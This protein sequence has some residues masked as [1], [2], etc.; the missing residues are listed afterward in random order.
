VEEE[1][2]EDIGEIKPEEHKCPR[3]IL[4]LCPKD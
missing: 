1:K 2:F 4:N 3:W